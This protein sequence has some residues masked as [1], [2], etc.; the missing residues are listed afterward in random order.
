MSKYQS[1]PAKFSI[2]QNFLTSQKT[3]ERLLKLTDINKNDTV[4]EI[5][6]GKGHITKA[7]LDKCGHVIACEID[8][9]LFGKLKTELPKCGNLSL[10]NVDFLDCS[11]PRYAY[12]VFSN[13]PFSI[14]TDIIRKLTQGNNP[15]QDA[16]LVMEKGAAKRF[17]GQP[18]DTLQSLLLRPFFDLSIVYHFRREDFHPMPHADAVLLHI[19]Q[20]T[21][22]D[23]PHN[24]RKS[25]YNFI[26]HGMRFGLS[27]K[28]ALLTRRQIHTALSLAKLNMIQPG[29][30]IL[31]IQWLCLFRCWQK[32]G[33]THKEMAHKS[34]YLGTSTTI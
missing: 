14:T 8:A 32:Y 15:P 28:G 7:L 9:K 10:N 1:R 31:Y 5:G 25:Y 11:L 24:E 23:I 6:A 30:E 17:C 33:R 20:R 12:K 4:L 13:I 26:T 2:S 21:H 34:H 22:P 16:W 29:G 27:G 19:S 3:I 18:G